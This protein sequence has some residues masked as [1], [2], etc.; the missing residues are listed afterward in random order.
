MEKIKWDPILDRHQL[1]KTSRG[2]VWIR[3]DKALKPVS[4]Y[5]KLDSVDDKHLCRDWLSEAEHNSEAARSL[6][7]LLFENVL[8][9]ED[10]ISNNRNHGRKKKSKK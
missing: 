8:K 6:A 4:I 9:A 10:I 3:Y 5:L 2:K 7:Q 1:G